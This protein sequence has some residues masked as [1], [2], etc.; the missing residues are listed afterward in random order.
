[1]HNRRSQACACECSVAK[2][3]TTVGI[4]IAGMESRKLSAKEYRPSRK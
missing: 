3:L 1:M 4:L 2:A